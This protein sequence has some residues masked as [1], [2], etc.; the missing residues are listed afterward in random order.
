VQAINYTDW[1][2]L[3]DVDLRISVHSGWHPSHLDVFDPRTKRS[4]I[5]MFRH[6]RDCTLSTNLTLTADKQVPHHSSRDSPLYSCV[7]K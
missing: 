7:N 2:V 4:R 1:C 5:V 6:N 3:S